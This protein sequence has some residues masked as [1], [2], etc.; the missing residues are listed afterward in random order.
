MRSNKS[1]VMWSV[2]DASTPLYHSP[3]RPLATAHI[4]VFS[5]QL[6]AAVKQVPIKSRKN[7]PQK[8]SVPEKSKSKNLP[9]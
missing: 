8:Y 7:N 9:S 1:N 5:G 2:P 6:F 3:I 4:G